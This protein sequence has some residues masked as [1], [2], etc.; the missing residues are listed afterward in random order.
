MGR[1]G[2]AHRALIPCPAA[3]KPSQPLAQHLAHLPIGQ[4]H[5]IGPHAGASGVGDDARQVGLADA[6]GR[7]P[8]HTPLLLPMPRRWNSPSRHGPWGR[9]SKLCWPVTSSR[10]LPKSAARSGNL[11]DVPAPNSTFGRR[12]IEKAAI[13][14]MASRGGHR[15]WP[16]WPLVAAPFVVGYGRSSCRR[17]ATPKATTLQLKPGKSCQAR[18]PV[19]GPISGMSIKLIQITVLGRPFQ[20]SSPLLFRRGFLGTAALLT[21]AFPLHGGP[22]SDPERDSPG[23]CGPGAQLHLSDA[24]GIRGPRGRRSKS[25]TPRLPQDRWHAEPIF[26]GWHR[27]TDDPVG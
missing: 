4:G 18:A 7:Q 10:R 19:L 14:G 21:G 16:R 27:G 11:R 1:S 3:G 8:R 17:K 22:L 20:V 2:A 6:K 23:L 15:S 24:A 26:A 9:A 12:E 25:H 13:M 5:R